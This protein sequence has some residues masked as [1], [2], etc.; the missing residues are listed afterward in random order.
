VWS[1]FIDTQPLL[2]SWIELLMTADDIWDLAAID[3]DA[4]VGSSTRA[5]RAASVGMMAAMRVHDVKAKDSATNEGGGSQPA[6]V[7]QGVDEDATMEDVAPV[8]LCFHMNSG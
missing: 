3:S 5:D 6:E 2:K 7:S 1:E 4:T 8:S